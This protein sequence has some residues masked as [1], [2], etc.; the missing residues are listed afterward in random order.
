M[1]GGLGSGVGGSTTL[2]S[3]AGVLD[4]RCTGRVIR[5]VEGDRIERVIAGQAQVRGISVEQMRKAMVERGPLE[6]FVTA[7]DIVDATVF[8]C[9]GLAG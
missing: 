5:T 3:L 4:A 1:P 7:N 6:R 2:G 8:F 9:G